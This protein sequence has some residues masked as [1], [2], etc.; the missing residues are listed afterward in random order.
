M[1][2]WRYTDTAGATRTA[3]S[4]RAGPSRSHTATVRQAVKRDN[5]LS[6]DTVR[7]FFIKPRLRPVLR[8]H[9]SAQLGQNNCDLFSVSPR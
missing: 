7:A 3:H 9:H 5:S 6:A 8:K 4:L 1:R 2:G